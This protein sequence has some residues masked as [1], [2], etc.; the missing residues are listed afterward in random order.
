MTVRMP[1]FS[2]M[3]RMRS[4]VSLQMGKIGQLGASERR[5]AQGSPEGRTPAL[6]SDPDHI[7]DCLLG[8]VELLA[9]RSVSGCG[10]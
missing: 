5:R 2:A 1:S 7:L 9:G 4:S 8:E 3:K 10:R 6:H